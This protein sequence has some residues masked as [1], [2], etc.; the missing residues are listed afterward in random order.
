MEILLYYQIWVET[1]IDYEELLWRHAPYLDVILQCHW[2]QCY[3]TN[4]VFRWVLYKTARWF[5]CCFVLQTSI[6]G[7]SQEAL[8]QL[9]HCPY[10]HI[11]FFASNTIKVFYQFSFKF[12]EIK[13][14]YKLCQTIFHKIKLLPDFHRVLIFNSDTFVE[15][16]AFWH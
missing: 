16:D 10:I 15:D 5:R 11:L 12:S 7:E 2:V 3:Q 14:L 4:P 9:A 8:L 13:R 6:Q 1:V